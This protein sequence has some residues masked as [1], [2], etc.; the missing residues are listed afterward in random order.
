VRKPGKLPA[1]VDEVAYTLEY[2]ENRLQMHQGSIER[3]AS[4]LVVDD[5]LATGGTAAATVEVVHRQGGVVAGFVFLVEL[6]FL[7][8]RKRLH[9][10]D[11]GV[12]VH[13]LIHVAG[14]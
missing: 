12:P 2:G 13:S 14:E 10:A 9:G 5:V 3:G 8:G 11:A 1:Q 6:D 4:V 7:G